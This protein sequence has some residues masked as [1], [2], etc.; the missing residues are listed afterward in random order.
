MR[1]LC[2]LTVVL[3]LISRSRFDLLMGIFDDRCNI[4][5]LDPTA[6]TWLSTNYTEPQINI[7]VPGK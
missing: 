1:F 6:R 5:T 3:V 4:L 2:Q 7:V